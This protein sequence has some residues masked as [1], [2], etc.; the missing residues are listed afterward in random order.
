LHTAGLEDESTVIT[1][2]LEPNGKITL[3]RRQP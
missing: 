1:A 3:I 2:R